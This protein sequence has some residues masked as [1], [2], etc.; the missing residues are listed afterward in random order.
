VVDLNNALVS[1]ILTGYAGFTTSAGYVGPNYRVDH[2]IS[3]L[4]P[5]IWCRL[6]IHERD[7]EFLISNG[8]LEKVCDFCLEGRTVLA[9]RLGYRITSAFAD[10][11]LGRIFELPGA[12]FTEELLRPE[13]QNLAQFAEGVD[14]IVEAQARVARLYFEDGSI[15]AAC[16]PLEALLHIMA[17]GH[18]RGMTAEDEGVRQLFRRDAMLASSWYRRRLLTKQSRDVALWTRHIA[19]LADVPDLSGTLE[20]ARRQLDRVSSPGYLAELEGTIGADPSLD[21]PWLSVPLR[22][23][24]AHMNSEPVQQLGAL[25]ELFGDALRHCQPESVAIL[26]VAGGNGLE[27]IDPSVT[28]RVCGIDINPEYLQAVRQRYSTLPGLELHCLDLAEQQVALPPVQLVYA[29]LIFEH[30]GVERCLDNAV[31][32]VAPGGVLSVVLQLPSATE[33]AVGSSSVASVQAQHDS[34]HFVDCGALGRQLEARGFR[35]VRSVR[36]PVASGKAFWMGLF[37]RP[38]A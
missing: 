28:S 10:H 29:A 3:M 37:E 9:S 16:P 2:D 15:A 13:K 21:H 30:A 35:F 6:Q 25:S 23:Y 18:Y 12:V 7:P 26:G 4:L 24:E 19:A 33:P 27:R 14:A 17:H 36:R 5:E 8:Y 31:D 20:E 1:A 34:F 22:D 11:F 38:T 32:L